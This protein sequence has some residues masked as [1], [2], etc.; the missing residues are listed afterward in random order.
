MEEQDNPFLG[1]SNVKETDQETPISD[2]DSVL[3]INKSAE[4]FRMSLFLVLSDESPFADAPFLTKIA[5]KYLSD[6]N[7]SSYFTT[8]DGFGACIVVQEGQA[9]PNIDLNIQEG[10]K[11]RNLRK[12][13]SLRI[14]EKDPTPE[15]IFYFAIG[16][17]LGHLIQ[18]LA[19]YASIEYQD[20]NGLTHTQIDEL[21]QEIE[22]YNN[23][24]KENKDILEAQEYFRRI[25]KTDINR[26]SSGA[27]LN[28]LDYSTGEYLRYVNSGAE[29]SADFISLWIMGM[30]NPSMKTSPQNEGYRIED[31]QQWANAHRIGEDDIA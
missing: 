14:G 20:V 2:T 1:I 31:W 4:I 5:E 15:D 13:V 24:I 7:Q 23:S 3:S 22:E 8:K 30:K 28:P 25:F 21:K 19:D 29:A 27:F 6:M 26:E 12:R 17:E 18:G 16:H 10:L 9:E 11:S